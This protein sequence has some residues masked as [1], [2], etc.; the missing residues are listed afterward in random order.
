MK[1]LAKITATRAASWLGRLPAAR[2][3]WPGVSEI[4]SVA[5]LSTHGLGM[6]DLLMASALFRPFLAQGSDVCVV[7]A[8]YPTLFEDVPAYAL[9]EWQARPLPDLCLVP[10]FSLRNLQYLG[11]LRKARFWA[12]FAYDWKLNGNF[13]SAV[14]GR[15]LSLKSH[16]QDRMELIGAALGLD[17]LDPAYHAHL[18]CDPIAEAPDRYLLLNLVTD[19]SVRGLRVD[20][21]RRIFDRLAEA[22]LKAVLVGDRRFENTVEQM[23]LAHPAVI[24][25]VG[26]TSIYELNTLIQGSLGYLGIDSGPMH[27]A[28]AFRKPVFAIMKGVLP[29]WRRP[30]FYGPEET[31]VAYSPC[32]PLKGTQVCYDPLAGFPKRCEGCTQAESFEALAPGL[33][34]FLGELKNA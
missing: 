8:K 30:R 24:S 17:S 19:Q 20:I 23:G 21:Y 9:A 33:E 4:R 26:K 18:K 3:D 31:F 14:S 13:D 12:G 29:A 5:L 10:D 27:V 16:W 15:A 2:H 22:G 1:R 34:K 25:K 11:T 7:G 6:G 32:E 28:F